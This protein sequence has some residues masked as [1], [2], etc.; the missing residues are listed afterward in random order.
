[1]SSD[2]E[3]TASDVDLQPVQPVHEPPS[4]SDT[5][6]QQVRVIPH[7]ASLR[8]ATKQEADGYRAGKEECAG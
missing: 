5:L 7:S 3:S 4:L 6:S 8:L 1:M 2:S